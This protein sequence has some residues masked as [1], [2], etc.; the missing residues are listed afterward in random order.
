M[1]QASAWLLLLVAAYEPTAN[2]RVESCEGWKV[3]V[4]AALHREQAELESR[5]LAL[6]RVKL[7]DIARVV[8]AAAVEKLRRAPVWVELEDQDIKCMNYHPS[9]AWLREHGYNPEKAGGIEIGNARNF[10]RWSLDQPWMVLHELA[11]YY[12][13]R[14]IGW[15]NAEIRQAYQTMVESH[16]YDAVLRVSG[17]R[18][19]HYALTNVKE[20]FAESTEAFFGTNDFYPFVRAELREEDPVMYELLAKYWRR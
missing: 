17:K 5:V 6:L 10:L 9:A 18:E 19:R 7:S 2:Y 13:D 11:H 14:V 1:V 20:Y 8:P 15:D 16:R 12:H 4:S 3:Y